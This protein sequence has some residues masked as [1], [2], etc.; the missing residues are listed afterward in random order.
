MLSFAQTG[1]DLRRPTT[2]LEPG[3]VRLIN[4]DSGPSSH[5]FKKAPVV[6]LVERFIFFKSYRHTFSEQTKDRTMTSS[7]SFDVRQPTFRLTTRQHLY[8]S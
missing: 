4:L 8:R 3:L 7:S 6:E 5:P 1:L 2:D